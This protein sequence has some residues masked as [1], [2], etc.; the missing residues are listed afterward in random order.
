MILK[1]NDRL[2]TPEWVYSRLGHIDLDPC[3]GI[4]TRIGSTNWAIE[5]GE[6]GLERTWF[7]FVYCN[8]PFS[9]KEQW[10]HKM[11]EHGSGILLLPERGST[12]W[13]GP[14]AEACKYHFTMGKKINFEGG[15]SS[16]PTGSTL[17]IFGSEALQ[18]IIDSGLPGTLNR[19]EFYRGRECA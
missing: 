11:V 16:N 19:V 13:H 2:Q 15:S 10:I 6:N 14:C 8:P 5:R 7:G 18:R 17:F 1:T 9:K 3:A 12:P 4:D